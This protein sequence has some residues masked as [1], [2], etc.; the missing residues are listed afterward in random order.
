MTVGLGLGLVTVSLLARP[1]MLALPIAAAWCA[2]L[3][4]A[5]DNGRAPPLA[6]ALLMIAWSNMHGGF[7]FGLALIGPFALEA[8][9]AAPRQARLATAGA[10]ALFGLAALLAALLNPYGVEALVF[11][12]RLMSVENLS[13]ISEWRAQDFSHVGPMEIALLALIGFALTR[14]LA[15]PQIRAALLILLIAMALEHA[16]HQLLLGILAPML[17]ARPVASAIGQPPG[18]GSAADRADCARR[19]ASSRAWPSA[20]RGSRRRSSASTE[21]PRR[22]PRSRPCRPSSGRSRS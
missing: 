4:A 17:L 10:W 8:L 13:R 19:D 1:H 3:L 6:L 15:A 9:A 12:F 21:R 14:P 2:G 16:R 7:V 5:R 20:P 11:P 18:A 22:S